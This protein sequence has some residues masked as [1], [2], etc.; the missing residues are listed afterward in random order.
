ME[1]KAIPIISF[2][3]IKLQILFLFFGAISRANLTSSAAT[4]GPGWPNE[5]HT[6][7]AGGH[8]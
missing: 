4:D 1:A 6:P 7:P 3:A 5:F 8:H 2:A